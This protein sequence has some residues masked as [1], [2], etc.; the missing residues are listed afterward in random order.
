[1]L[2]LLMVMMVL[3][4]CLFGLWDLNR[5]MMMVML[6]CVVV[7]CRLEMNGLLRGC[8]VVASLFVVER[9]LNIV[10]LGNSVK[11][12]FCDAVVVVSCLMCLRLVLMFL[13]VL[14]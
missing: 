4:G 8:V 13:F 7:L 3:C 14:I 12:V 2:L 5:L 11:W 9:Y 10:F 6:C 1:M